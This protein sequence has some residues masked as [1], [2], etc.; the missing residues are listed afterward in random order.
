MHF[1]HVSLNHRFYV[2]HRIHEKHIVYPDL[3]SVQNCT[4]W[5]MQVHSRTMELQSSL[6]DAT[7][8]NLFL[9]RNFRNKLF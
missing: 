1:F 5:N 8:Y 2:M 3:Y 4:T 7:V 6:A 9:P